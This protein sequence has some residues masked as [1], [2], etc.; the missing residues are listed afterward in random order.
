MLPQKNGTNKKEQA[1]SSISISE[2]PTLFC[3]PIA[4]YVGR[5]G[6]QGQV[7]ARCTS[8]PHSYSTA[9]GMLTLENSPLTSAPALGSATVLWFGSTLLL[10]SK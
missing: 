2:T 6:A 7:C 5:A 8:S 4:C 10:T 1:S 3:P 9:L